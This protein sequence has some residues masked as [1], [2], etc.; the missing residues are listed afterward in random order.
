MEP[1]RFNVA[2]QRHK[3]AHHNGQHKDRGELIEKDGHFRNF[4]V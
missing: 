2:A 3:N 1:G 4:P